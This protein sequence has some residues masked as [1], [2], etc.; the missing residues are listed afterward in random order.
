[1]IYNC[2]KNNTIK[3]NQFEIRPISINDIEPIRVWRNK[4]MDVLRQKNE[5]TEEEQIKYYQNFI[6]PTFSQ[7]FPN[8]IIFSFLKSDVLIGYGGLV[9]ISWED[10]RAEMSFLLDPKY[11]S[12]KVLYKNYFQEF[13]NCMKI[14]NFQQLH[15][16]KLFTET[17]SHRKFH[18]S[19]LEESGFKI[20]GILKDHIILNNN[21]INS[22]IHSIINNDV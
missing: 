11:I 8:Q 7:E 10:K 15:F 5:I 2:L 20:E 12:E 9:H 6:V 21:Y 22:L 14:V 3:N 17:Y 18:I 16:H 19:V 1:M 4:Q 13:I